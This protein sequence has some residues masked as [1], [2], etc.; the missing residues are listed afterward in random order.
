LKSKKLWTFARPPRSLSDA[1]GVRLMVA[2]LALA[3][4]GA[5]AAQAASRTVLVERPRC[6]WIGPPLTR[7][8]PLL[9]QRGVLNCA[10]QQ[11]QVTLHQTAEAGWIC[12]FARPWRQTGDG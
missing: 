12:F 11:C 8:N 4:L 1:G 7:V 2:G 10:L 9:L 3:A 6:Y 5:L